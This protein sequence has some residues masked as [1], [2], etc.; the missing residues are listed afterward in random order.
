MARKGTQITPTPSATVQM[1]SV[2]KQ[3]TRLAKQ[4]TH[5]DC[6]DSDS[7]SD[8]SDGEDRAS[9]SS[10]SPH[11]TLSS[12]SEEDDTLLSV[13]DSHNVNSTPTAS[14][15]FTPENTELS[16]PSLIQAD[17][18]NLPDSGTAD[19]ITDTRQ[20]LRKAFKD[21]CSLKHI[22]GLVHHDLSGYSWED[23]IL[24]QSV[25]DPTL[26]KRKRMVVPKPYRQQLLRVAHDNSGLFHSN[27]Q[28]FSLKRNLLGPI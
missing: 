1:A 24:F 21:D 12:S 11:E 8:I 18:P 6:H 16:E 28:L 26:G 13:D 4:T 27:V 25:N 14:P 19:N 15:A 7:D 22:R 17:T 10:F 20:A 3:P 23:G 9:D 2:R 5:N